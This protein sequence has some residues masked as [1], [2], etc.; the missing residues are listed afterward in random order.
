[1]QSNDR[2]WLWVLALND[3]VVIVCDIE[4]SDEPEPRNRSFLVTYVDANSLI[5]CLTNYLGQ[6]RAIYC[7][8]SY[9][10]VRVPNE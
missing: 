3:N 9:L 10:F 5:I 8:S 1:M 6:S 7:V 2:C 4:N